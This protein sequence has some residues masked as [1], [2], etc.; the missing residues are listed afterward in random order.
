MVMVAFARPQQGAFI[1][2]DIEEI[3][4]EKIENDVRVH[5]SAIWNDAASNGG[6]YL[7]GKEEA[8]YYVKE[9]SREWRSARKSLDIILSTN[10]VVGVDK[11]LL[12]YEFMPQN[13]IYIYIYLQELEKLICKMR[14]KARGKDSF[15]WK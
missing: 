15:N 13:A 8:E 12:V 6:K 1:I 3:T 10:D 11:Y 9:F 14:K 7:E 4:P 5:L 2:M